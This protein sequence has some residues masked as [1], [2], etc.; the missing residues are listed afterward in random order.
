[1][2]NGEVINHHKAIDTFVEVIVKLGPEE[3]LKIDTER[4]LI[5]TFPFNYPGKADKQ[6]GKYYI[7]TNHSTERKQKLFNK[8]ASRLGVSLEVEIID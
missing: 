3:V 1:M 6:D 8:I 4:M 5:S 7:S 2:P